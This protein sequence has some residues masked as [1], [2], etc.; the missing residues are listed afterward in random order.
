MCVFGFKLLHFVSANE[1]EH[2]GHTLPGLLQAQARS[3]VSTALKE[4]LTKKREDR[5]VNETD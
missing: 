1:G 4:G 3:R 5:A 2:K